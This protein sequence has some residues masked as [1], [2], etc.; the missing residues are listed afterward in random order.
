VPQKPA[1]GRLQVANEPAATKAALM[2]DRWLSSHSHHRLAQSRTG[3]NALDCAVDQR[4]ATEFCPYSA[5]WMH[6]ASGLK[7]P[8]LNPNP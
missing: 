6:P 2:L 5:A 7:L 8:C 1:E 4:F 3:A